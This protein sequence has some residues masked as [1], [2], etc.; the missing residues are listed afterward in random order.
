MKRLFTGLMALMLFVGIS[1]FAADNTQAKLRSTIY[2]KLGL[3]ESKKL[4]LIEGTVE[5]LPNT[6]DWHVAYIDNEDFGNKSKMIS[7]IAT[8]DTGKTYLE[9][10]YIDNGLLINIDDQVIKATDDE[11]IAD[12]AKLK[13]TGKYVQ[14]SDST[15]FQCFH[16][17]GQNEKV[18]YNLSREAFGT[19]IYHSVYKEKL[20]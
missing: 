17:K 10:F 9:T 15:N 13:A 6:I 19:K 2:S 18:C 16:K 7:Y 12:V 14:G 20:K 1:S 11:L 4:E 5:M 3:S 8:T